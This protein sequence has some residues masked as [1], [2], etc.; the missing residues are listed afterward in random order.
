V[1]DGERRRG[2]ELAALD[3][4]PEPVQLLKRSIV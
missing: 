2:Y 1:P 4:Q 3:L